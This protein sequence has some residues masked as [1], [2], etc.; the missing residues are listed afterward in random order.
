MQDIQ[1]LNMNLRSQIIESVL[2]IEKQS[3]DLLKLIFRLFN[4]KTKTLGN[5][6][7]S[8]SLKTKIDFLYDFGDISNEEYSEFIKLMEIR[9]QFAHNAE[10]V[11]FL[12]LDSFNPELN[13]FLRN[14]H[15][16]LFGSNGD[17]ELTI[18]SAFLVS[19]QNCQSKL[20]RLTAEYQ[21][22]LKSE[23]KKHYTYQSIDGVIDIFENLYTNYKET[24]VEV[25]KLNERKMEG[26]S[27]KFLKD[28]K[29]ALMNESEFQIENPTEE[30]KEVF[31]KKVPIEDKKS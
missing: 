10:A 30:I 28:F 19:A 5:S 27:E 22:G 20:S 9:N 13:K 8:I 6:S 21:N 31:I 7:S 25:K 24:N 17:A 18:K 1:D 12:A 2:I 26:I 29:M 11:S 16:S 3:K 15:M 23:V 14:K 4:H